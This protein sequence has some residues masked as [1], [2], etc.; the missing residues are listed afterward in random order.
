M[1]LIYLVPNFQEAASGAGTRVV[2]VSVRGRADA[3]GPRT[4][5]KRA[6]GACP[7][8][9]SLMQNR[10]LLDRTATSGVAEDATWEQFTAVVCSRLQ[11][12]GLKGVFHADSRA[13]LRSMDELQDVEDLEVEARTQKMRLFLHTAVPKIP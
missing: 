3:K 1:L 4:R 13:E 9:S 10:L 6:L 12:R 5:R 8:D 2:F 7:G 11:L